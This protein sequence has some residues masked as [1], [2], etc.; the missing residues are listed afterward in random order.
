MAAIRSLLL[1]LY[2]KCRRCAGIIARSVPNTYRNWYRNIRRKRLTNRNFTI[3]CNNCCGGVMYHELKERFLSPTINLS[4]TTEDYFEFLNHLQYYI[5]TAPVQIPFPDADYPVGR[6]T[7]EDTGI[8]IHFM[9][10][11][12]FDEAREKWLE[13]GKRVNMDN[14]YVVFN[15]YKPNYVQEFL[16]LEYTHKAM[17]TNC[18]D[19]D[20]IPEGLHHIPYYACSAKQNGILD[21]RHFFSIRRWLDDF[22]YVSFLNEK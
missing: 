7:R 14:L 4:F 2:K 21:H 20:T 9:H 3:I 16:D 8:N 17:L 22:D 12:S 18:A 5:H 19:M 15:T 10:Y 13:R 1:S 11:A 6:I